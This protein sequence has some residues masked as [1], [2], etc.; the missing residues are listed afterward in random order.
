MYTYIY[1]DTHVHTY[2]FTLSCIDIWVYLYLSIYIPP[3]ATEA[4]ISVA[5]DRIMSVSSPP[6]LT[7]VV[8]QYS[9]LPPASLR[10]V[11][12]IVRC[13]RSAHAF[14]AA[15]SVSSCSACA[16]KASTANSFNSLSRRSLRSEPEPLPT[17][18]AA[19]RGEAW[20]AQDSQPIGYQVTTSVFFERVELGDG[21]VRRL[22]ARAPSQATRGHSPRVYAALAQ[23]CGKARRRTAAATCVE[24]RADL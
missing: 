21:V 13:A 4:Y 24:V 17:A 8:P 7:D 2:M 12:A 5:R 16:R 11:D 6:Q 10:A 14:A 23:G 3:A 20:G 1:I 15:Y 18:A 9:A 22:A 19:A